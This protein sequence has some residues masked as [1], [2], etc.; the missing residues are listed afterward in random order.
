M[1]RVLC[2]EIG[3]CEPCWCFRGSQYGLCFLG[4]RG[5]SRCAHYAAHVVAACYMG[6]AVGGGYLE[7]FL[8]GSGGALLP[9]C[10]W[11]LEA[12]AMG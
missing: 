4:L 3:E 10:V 11:H 6:P 1:R 8:R 7:A 12:L 5:D 9:G 2:L